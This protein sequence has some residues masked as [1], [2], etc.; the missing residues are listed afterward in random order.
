MVDLFSIGVDFMG[1]LL[2]NRLDRDW[3][4]ASVPDYR[5]KPRAADLYTKEKQKTKVRRKK[6]KRGK[7]EKT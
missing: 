3:V 1:E 5:F 4:R 6:W 2:A 7:M